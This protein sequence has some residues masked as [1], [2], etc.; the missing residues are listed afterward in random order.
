MGVFSF[1]LQG[2]ETCSSTALE[3]IMIMMI[4]KKSVLNKFN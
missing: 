3:Q 2:D 4:E 1:L